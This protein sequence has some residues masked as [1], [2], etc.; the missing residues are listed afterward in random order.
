[1]NYDSL[2]NEKHKPGLN[3]RHESRCHGTLAFCPNISEAAY[4]NFI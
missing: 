4:S 1:M 3:R 2:T